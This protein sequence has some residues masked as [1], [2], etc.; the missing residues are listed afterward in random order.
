MAP[1]FVIDGT[2]TRH[3]KRFNSAG[4]Q[5]TVRL[6]PPSYN[7]DPLNHF[8]ASVNDFF[9]NVLQNMSDSDMV[10][11]TI[12]NDVNQSDKPIGISF[13]RKD[14]LSGD[15]IWSV[16]EKVAQSNSRFNALDTLVVNV[17]SGKMPVGFGGGG[18]KTISI[19]VSVLAHL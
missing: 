1:R 10:G 13:R 5:I 14:Q 19:P 7:V 4:T 18:T 8:Q 12:H 17:H 6:L 11:M 15:V 16:Y 9:E 3:Y 2:I